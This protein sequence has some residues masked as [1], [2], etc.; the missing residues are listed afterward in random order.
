MGPGMDMAIFALHL[1][2]ASSIMGSIN[3][4]VTVL[5]MRA[6]GDINEDAHVLLDLAH[7]CLSVDCCHASIGRGDYDGFNGSS[8]WY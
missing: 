1:L 3:I 2:G 4:I 7:Y 8:F 6:P 5:N